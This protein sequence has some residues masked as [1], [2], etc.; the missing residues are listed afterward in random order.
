MADKDSIRRTTNLINA[1]SHVMNDEEYLKH[2][3]V[4]GMRWGVRRPT[5]SQGLVSGRKGASDYGKKNGTK[6]E[7]RKV[8]G[9]KIQKLRMAKRIGAVIGVNKALQAALLP[10][11]LSINP[12]S[13]VA[14]GLIGARLGAVSKVHAAVQRKQTAQAKDRMEKVLKM[15]TK[16]IDMK[17]VKD[18]RKVASRYG[19]IEIRKEGGKWVKIDTG[20]TKTKGA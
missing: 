20:S 3:G 1:R 12:T 13:L 8:E 10:I 15:K 18:F 19:Q 9:Q 14:I 16:D 4:Q 11:H 2:F 17:S 7:V 6:V 5:N